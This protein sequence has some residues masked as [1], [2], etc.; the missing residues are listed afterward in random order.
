MS[1]LLSITITTY[2]FGLVAWFTVHATT[3][4]QGGWLHCVESALT[5]PRDAYRLIRSLA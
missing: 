4:W 1:A 5:W 2:L 3:G